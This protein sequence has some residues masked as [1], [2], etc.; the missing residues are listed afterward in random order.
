M[1]APLDP[2]QTVGVGVVAL[3]LQPLRHFQVLPEG[4]GVVLGGQG[5]EEAAVVAAVL[6]SHL[7]LQVLHIPA[8][9]ALM[10]AVVAVVAAV[11]TAVL[12]VAAS[13]SS[14][15]KRST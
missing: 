15:R 8:A 10:V 7:A 4:L 12:A 3:T 6:G 9:M 2:V 14:T 11:L 5:T 1:E 13:F